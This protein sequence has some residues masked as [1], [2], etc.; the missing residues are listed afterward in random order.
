MAGKINNI[1]ELNEAYRQLFHLED[2]C[3]LPLLTSIVI[4]AKTSLRHVWLYLIGASSSGKTALLSSFSRVNFVETISDFTENTF[5][6]GARSADGRETSLL[7]RLGSNFVIIMKDF[8][9]ILSKTEEAQDRLMSQMREIYDG[10]MRKETGT[11]FTI[12][13]GK[14]DKSLRSV[15]LMAATEAIYKIQSRFSE[16]GSRGL[17]YVIK[18]TDRKSV[19]RMALS[20]TEGFDDKLNELQTEVADYVRRKCLDLPAKFPELSDDFNDLIIN[21]AEFV[22]RARS[23][24][25]R[26]YRGA[27]MLALSAEMPMRVA[28][29]MQAVAKILIHLNEG[30]DEEWIRRTVV[31]CAYDC[32]PKQSHLVLRHLAEYSK[33][34]S[35]AVA[36][37]TGYPKDRAHEWL[38]DL[39]MHKVVDADKVAGKWYWTM[40]KDDKRLMLAYLNLTEKFETLDAADPDDPFSDFSTGNDKVL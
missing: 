19:T 38:E 32:I 40:D 20:K 35:E 1:R 25:V 29:Q 10:Y 13:W 2:D 31:K 23:V 18:D 7:K 30:K 6:S 9:T 37:M 4:N 17:N 16:M 36:S 24:V 22:T 8:T 27:I 21:T 12:E 26:D 3:V 39:R 11:G 33:V 14:K 34:T 28:T 15:F 5:L